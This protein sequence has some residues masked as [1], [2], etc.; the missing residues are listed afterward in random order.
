M[1][2]FIVVVIKLTGH[3]LVMCNMVMDLM[4]II[5]SI[6]FLILYIINIFSLHVLSAGFF[7]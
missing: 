6:A 4:V 2:G 7:L 5:A 3:L 1:A